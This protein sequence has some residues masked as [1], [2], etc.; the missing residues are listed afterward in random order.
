MKIT[1]A[2]SE[3]FVLLRGFDE[4]IGT[5]VT[6]SDERPCIVVYLD[7]ASQKVLDKIPLRYK[8]NKVKTEISDHFYGFC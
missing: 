2:S 5:G 4:V 7:K 1:D 3:L 6:T 8:G